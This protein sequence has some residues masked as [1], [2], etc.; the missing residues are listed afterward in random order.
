MGWLLTAAFAV[1]CYWLAKEAKGFLKYVLFIFAAVLAVAALQAA[2]AD[3]RFWALVGAIV[4]VLLA[5]KY[6]EWQAKK[7]K[8]RKERERHG[9]THFHSH[10]YNRP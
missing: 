7:R 2:F 9:G 10:Y 6:R 1:G 8:K 4:G 5:Y 3:W